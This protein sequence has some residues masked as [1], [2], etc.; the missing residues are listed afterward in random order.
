MD[1]CFKVC[2]A[3]LI[4]FYVYECFA[5]Q[6]LCAPH[7]SWFI[8]R[9]EEGGRFYSFEL[10]LGMVVSCHVDTSLNPDLRQEQQVLLAT[11]S[12][13]LPSLPPLNTWGSIALW[14]QKRASDPLELELQMVVS[15][16]VGVR[17]CTWVLCKSRK[18][19]RQTLLL[20]GILPRTSPELH[21]PL[22]SQC[23]SSA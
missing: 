11:E 4:L 10:Q 12:P 6:Y 13:L 14:G 7:V 23:F 9:S 1:L 8:R 16:H 18:E 3:L 2:L 5:W 22:L 19:G 17:N 21:S 15:H 20:G